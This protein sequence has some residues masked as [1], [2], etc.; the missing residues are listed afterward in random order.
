MNRVLEFIIKAKDNI[1]EVMSRVAKK[2]EQAKEAASEMAKAVAEAGKR[3][4]A[5]LGNITDYAAEAD[6]KVRGMGTGYKSVLA[7][8]KELADKA[9]A[10]AE[11]KKAETQAIRQAAGATDDF[12]HA[13]KSTSVNW[14]EIKKH[15]EA[16]KQRKREIITL[17]RLLAKEEAA[18]KATSGD[19]AKAHLANSEMIKKGIS[20]L[21]SG[22]TQDMNLMEA[23]M[24]VMSGN[25]VGIG[26]AVVQVAAK[27]KLLGMSMASMSVYTLAIIAV[28]KIFTWWK[29]KLDECAQKLR[30]LKLEAMTTQM[31]GLAK[32]QETVNKR[33]EEGNKALEKA[34]AH[35]Q[36]MLDA[37]AALQKNRNELAREKE[38]LGAKDEA[39][40]IAI[41][42][43][44]DKANENID[45][46]VRKEKEERDLA[47]ARQKL[48][49]IEAAIED[50][51]QLLARARKE[52]E[53][54]YREMNEAY[55]SGDKDDYENAKKI[56]NEAVT[57]TKELAKQKEQLEETRTDL[58]NSIPE[59]LATAKAN[60]AGDEVTA[61]KRAQEEKAAAT[62]RKVADEENA[63]ELEA[64]WMDWYTAYSDA[65]KNKDSEIAQKKCQLLQEYY[66]LLAQCT[67]E[68]ER[69]QLKADYDEQK[70]K[71][72]FLKQFEDEEKA[73]RD[74]RKA[75]ELAVAKAAHEQRIRN[76]Q[77]ELAESQKAQQKAQERAQAAQEAVSQAWGWYKDKDSLKRQ[78][79]SEESDIAARQQYAKDYQHLTKGR[80]ADE[81]AEAQYQQRHGRTDKVEELM[82]KW[83]KGP[84]G[85]SIEDEATMRVAL[86]QDAEKQANRDLANINEATA[87]SAAAV[88]EIK[89]LLKNG[90]NE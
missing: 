84:F 70:Y 22:A 44:W 53:K 3:G 89:D 2:F 24:N 88:E 19:A 7:M 42:S 28:V 83:R 6:K 69:Q 87:R 49:N 43:K 61:F 41:N 10:H 25:L 1:S 48:K 77:D 12:S 46:G 90:G 65:A 39:E 40:K 34:T 63:K 18:A 27:F 76:T 75:D 56:F 35:Q 82:A 47:D 20:S 60:A 55:E 58:Q 11:A 45:Q 64:V 23:G 80:W 31:N 57:R 62:A 4:M 81:F 16:A 14:D 30:D 37:S 52:R 54:A 15:E 67:D 73:A 66:D 36:K 21:R 79:S 59:M 38:L 29:D 5:A 72:D 86:A 17:T 51:A 71:L 85:L 74:K 8:E 13:L 78:I 68:A 26:K 32:A 9:K 50:N 33:L